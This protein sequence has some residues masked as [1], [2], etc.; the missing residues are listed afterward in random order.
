LRPVSAAALW[1]PLARFVAAEARLCAWAQ[2]R[3]TTYFIYEFIRFG[4]KQAWACLFGGLMVALLIGTFLLYPKDA[5]LARYDFLVL[6]SIAIQVL[7]IALKLESREEALVILI[8]HGVG[9]AMEIFKTQMG[10]WIYPE[11]SLLRIGGVPLFT[12]FMYAAVGSY[13]ARAWRLFDF[14]FTRYPPLWATVLLAGAIYVNF[15]SHHYM[16]DLR[17]ALFAGI[18]LLYGRC[19]IHYRVHTRFRTMPLMLSSGLVTLFIWIA[20]NVGTLTRAWI[21]PHQKAGFEMVALAK[22]GSWYL[23]V[24][25]SAVLVSLVSP[26][27]PMDGHKDM[28]AEPSP[29]GQGK[30]QNA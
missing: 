11:P 18:A 2:K 1:P 3:P 17:I 6:A 7:L 14:R 5:W 9:T 22:F 23:L 8:F 20:E 4:V 21:Y 13:I 15:F 30:R 12:G 16:P 29:A 24:M 10:S 26:P 19:W 27:K 28:Q 25:I